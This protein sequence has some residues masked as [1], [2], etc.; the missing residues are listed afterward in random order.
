MK[1]YTLPCLD[2]IDWSAAE[3]QF[4]EQCIWS[5]NTAPAATVQGLYLKDKA[6]VFRLVSFAAPTRAVNTEADSSVWE[7]SCLECFFSF[8]NLNYV[9]LEANANSALLAFFGAGRVNRKPLRSLGIA[10][11]EVRA[12][13][14]AEGWELI[15]SIPFET[16]YALWG[17]RVKSGDSFTANFYS[18]GDKTPLPHYASWNPVETESPDF[19]R[20]EFFGKII[21]G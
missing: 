21:I 3:P 11:P 9:N 10:M 8:D 6:L 16:I 17:H 19:H 2:S 15:F 18:C 14:L 4:I 1:T 20:P 12:A 13:K 7:D 5:P